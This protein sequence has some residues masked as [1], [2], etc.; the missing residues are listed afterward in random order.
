MTDYF[1]S[2]NLYT[3]PFSCPPT[4]LLYLTKIVNIEHGVYKKGIFII[5]QKNWIMFTTAN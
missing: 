4:Y 3:H 5:K 1:S 2:Y